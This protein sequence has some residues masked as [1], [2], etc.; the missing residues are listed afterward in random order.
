MF[1]NVI[2]RP[3]KE[4][5]CH[6]PFWIPSFSKLTSLRCREWEFE[7]LMNDLCGCHL[8]IRSHIEYDYPVKDVIGPLAARQQLIRR[9]TE[10]TKEGGN[11]A[12]TPCDE[13]V[14]TVGFC[15]ELPNE[16][17]GVFCSKVR[18]E[19]HPRGLAERLECKA[20][21]KTVLR[22]GSGI[23]AVDLDREAFFL[24][25]LKVFCVEMR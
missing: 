6:A 14:L 4:S 10:G 15:F 16:Q 12:V 8:T 1:L 22:V 9:C 3:S 21:T 2:Q 17:I 11:F 13:W 25:W 20:R 7:A 19:G 24:K 5:G 23:E 18:V